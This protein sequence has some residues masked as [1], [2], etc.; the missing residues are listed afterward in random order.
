MSAELTDGVSSLPRTR[1][2]RLWPRSLR[3]WLVRLASVALVLVAW[4]LYAPHVNPIFLRPPS[5]VATAFLTLAGDGVLVRATLESV[6]NLLIGLTL[7]LVSGLAIG[8][9]S[10]RSWLAYNAVNPWLTALY[11]TPSV[12]L[13]PFMSLWLGIGDT[14]KVAV[15]ALFAVFPILINT[16]QGV[17][18]VDP[19]LLEVARSFRSTEWRLWRDVLLPAALPFIFAGVRLAVPRALVGMVLAEFLISVGGGLGSLIIVYQNTFRVDRMLVPVIVVAA[20]G[21]VLLAAVQWLERRLAPWA[22][23]DR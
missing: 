7:A 2:V 17:R 14:A 18:Y 21:V 11:S 3:E 9:A 13:V 1:R 23:R 20:M 15:I 6:H 8:L 16:Q 12:A 22:R 19:Q 10:S 5:Q 4:E